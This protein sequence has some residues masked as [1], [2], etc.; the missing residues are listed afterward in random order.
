M[1][2]REQEGDVDP[3]TL[4]IV[5]TRTFD[6]PPD[7]VFDAFADPARLARW[8]G[9]S[10]FTSTIHELDLRPGGAL[11]LTMHGP[12]G[13]DYPSESVFLEVVK[14]ERIVFRDARNT[15]SNEYAFALR[16]GRIYVRLAVQGVGLAGEPWRRLELPG[17]LDGRVQEIS[18]DHRLLVALGPQRQV[19]SHDMPG[20]DLSAERWTW[21]W[22]PYFWTGSGMRMWEDVQQW[23]TSELTSAEWFRD[24]TGAAPAPPMEFQ[25]SCSDSPMMMPSGPRRKQSR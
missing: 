19:Y 2:A 8:W 20:G 23:A 13:A 14:P 10:G 12:D 18:A 24:S 5:S 25:L 16:G 22:G 17:C 15:Y 4:E 11:R 7:R 3:S 1:T 9:P 21:R 6:V